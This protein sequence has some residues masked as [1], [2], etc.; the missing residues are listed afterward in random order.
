ME[1]GAPE[2]LL[3]LAIALVVFGP[4]KI[5]EIGRSLGRSIQEFKAGMQEGNSGDDKKTPPHTS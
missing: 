2:I 4:S 5:P 3:I 1:L